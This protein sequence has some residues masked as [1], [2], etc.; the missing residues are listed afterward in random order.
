MIQMLLNKRQVA[1]I[2][3]LH[4]GTVMRLVREGKFP[5]PLRTGDKGSAVRWRAQDVADWIKSRLNQTAA[6]SEAG[7]E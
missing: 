6:G 3:D 5:E 1:H 2:I 4:E 7:N